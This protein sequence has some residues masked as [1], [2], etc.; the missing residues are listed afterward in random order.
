M[1]KAC[2]AT[3]RCHLLSLLLLGT[4]G[5]C[6]AEQSDAP[7]EVV[8]KSYLINAEPSYTSVTKEPTVTPVPRNFLGLVDFNVKSTG[9][10]D[11]MVCYNLYALAPGEWASRADS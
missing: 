2:R 7:C 10:S 5:I 9:S 1:M 8:V 11:I 4:L 3:L 6:L